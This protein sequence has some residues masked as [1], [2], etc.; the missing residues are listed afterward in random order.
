MTDQFYVATDQFYV[1]VGRIYFVTKDFYVATKL[2]K[3][4]SSTAH[5]RAGRAKA[6]AHH[7]VA[8]CCVGTKEAM[9]A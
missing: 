4:E 8:P 9:R 5:N 3:T 7:S 2:T 6:G 1:R